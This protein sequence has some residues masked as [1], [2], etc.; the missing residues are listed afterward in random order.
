[1][2]ISPIEFQGVITRTQDV[3]SIQHN[4]DQ[5]G[6]L[7]QSNFQMQMDKTIEHNLSQV[8]NA[9]NADKKQNQTDAKEKG[10]GQYMG[11]GGKNRRKREETP[12]DGKVIR[13]GES[14]FDI[15]I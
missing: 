1:M 11:D 6:M 7:H 5:K 14:H 10:N 3:T 9:D 13:K 2:A 8:R 4:E 15:S 12:A